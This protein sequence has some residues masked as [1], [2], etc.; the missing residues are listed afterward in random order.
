MALKAI[1]SKIYSAEEYLDLED[2]SESRSEFVAEHVFGMAGGTDSHIQIS[3]NV[4]KVLAEKLRGKCRS[5]QSEMKVRVEQSDAFYYPDVTLVCGEQQFYKGRRD[6]I[7]NPVL[8]GEVLSESK[9]DYDKNDKFFAY[10]TIPSFKEY[11]L[12]SQ[13]KHAVQQYI[14][15]PDGNWKIKATIGIDSSVYLESV[16][17]EILTRDIYDLVEII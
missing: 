10:Q 16:D 12:I 5:Y 4:T 2:A 13:N 6:V 7:E 11:L 9:K 8:L 15:Q 14:R 1:I 17:V 3:F